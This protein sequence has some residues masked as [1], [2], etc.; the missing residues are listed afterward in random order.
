MFETGIIMFEKRDYHVLRDYHVCSG[1][2]HVCS[3]ECHVCISR[4]DVRRE[5]F[6]I[7]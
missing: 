6:P 5:P 7:R 4:Q 3:G 1:D 2:Y